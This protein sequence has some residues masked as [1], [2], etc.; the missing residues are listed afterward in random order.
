MPGYRKLQDENAVELYMRDAMQ[1][2]TEKFWKPRGF[3]YKC[4]KN[5]VLLQRPKPGNYRLDSGH[6]LCYKKL[7]RNLVNRSML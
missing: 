1:K 6:G 7:N 3:L 5:Y 2:T 4:L